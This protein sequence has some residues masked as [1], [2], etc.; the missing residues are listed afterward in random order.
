MSDRNEQ[1]H[2]RP[3]ACPN[4]EILVQPVPGFLRAFV[5]RPM[6]MTQDVDEEHQVT[7][8]E[9]PAL[10]GDQIINDT[11]GI[12]TATICHLNL[13]LLQFGRS[14]NLGAQRVEDVECG[15]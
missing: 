8:H 4:V 15:S 2:A 14:R 11:L 5:P 7:W 1:S 3:R 9:D 10:D 12:T 13:E 6:R